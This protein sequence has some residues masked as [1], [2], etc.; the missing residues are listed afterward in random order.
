MKTHASFSIYSVVRVIYWGFFLLSLVFTAVFYAEETTALDS[1][2]AEA[3]SLYFKIEQQ[4]RELIIAEHEL[5]KYAVTSDAAD[6]A[7]ET[8]KILRDSIKANT[9][10]LSTLGIQLIEARKYQD[11]LIKKER[12]A[13]IDMLVASGSYESYRT[14]CM[15]AH[16]DMG[17]DAALV[18]ARKLGENLENEKQY[19]HAASLYKQFSV[20]DKSLLVLYTRALQKNT[21]IADARKCEEAGDYSK[22]LKIYQTLALPIDSKRVAEKQARR[23]EKNGKIAQAVRAYETAGLL[24]EARRLRESNIIDESLSAAAANSSDVYESIAPAVVTVISDKSFGSGFFIKTGGYIVTNNHVI[25][26]QECKVRTVDKKEY[27][28]AL[29]YKSITPDIAI[30]KIAND[31]HPVVLL[32]D[33]DTV[34]VGQPVSA[35]GTPYDEYLAGTFT[36]GVISATDRTIFGNSVFQIDVAINKG[37]SGGP[38]LDDHG[39]VI[40]VNTFGLGVATQNSQGTIGSGVEGI[41]FAIK[42]NEVKPIISTHIPNSP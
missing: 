36:Q 13:Q 38:L 30:I 29:I 25:D 14:A 5:N 10:K 11:D 40:G 3:S 28:A 31:S 15:L 27:K 6:R 22:A 42:I 34:K 35:I 41:N 19:E 37:N 24:S 4:K 32:G 7:Y 33:S 8:V 1:T 26:G 9:A 18:L 23:L 21:D 16:K 39:N 20:L 17:P 2:K 12:K